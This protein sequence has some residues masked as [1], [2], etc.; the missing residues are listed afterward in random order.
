MSSG[1]SIGDGSY[2]DTPKNEACKGALGPV[3]LLQP[4]AQKL[5]TVATEVAFRALPKYDLLG[6]NVAFVSQDRCDNTPDDDN[7]MGSPELVIEVLSPS[8]PKA[9]SAPGLACRPL[10]EY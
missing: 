3:R 1:G 7:L 9:R 5:G 10:V 6:A 8:V 4:F 2:F